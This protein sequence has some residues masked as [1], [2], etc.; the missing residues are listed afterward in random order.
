MGVSQAH[1][2]DS[3]EA[4]LAG[5]N[6]RGGERQMFGVDWGHQATAVDWLIAS[7]SG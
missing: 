2:R 5:V 7:R 4:G 6:E 3:K 1:L